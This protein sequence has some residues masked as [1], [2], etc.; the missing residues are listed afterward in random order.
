M[1]PLP[2]QTQL[3]SALV[4]DQLFTAFL[5]ANHPYYLKLKYMQEL[6]M[7]SATIPF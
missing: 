3:T 7:D 6:K 4:L 1:V 2:K 5:Q